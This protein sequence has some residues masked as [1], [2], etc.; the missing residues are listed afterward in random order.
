MSNGAFGAVIERVHMG[1]T[2]IDS[3]R[4]RG[5]SA[6]ARKIIC[7][8]DVS[9]FEELARVSLDQML[10]LRNCGGVTAREIQLMVFA[11][12]EEQGKEFP[13][14][15]IGLPPECPVK[16]RILSPRCGA[17]FRRWMARPVITRLAKPE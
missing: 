12:A 14:G 11:W 7:K 16:E 4:E 10:R 1:K 8:L 2:F 5:L 17:S 9:S 3:L 15:S 6:R 13:V